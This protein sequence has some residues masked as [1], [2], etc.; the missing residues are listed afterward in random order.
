MFGSKMNL[1]QSWALGPPEGSVW[2]RRGIRFEKYWVV[3][4]SWSRPVGVGARRG[5]GDSERLGFSE[6]RKRRDRSREG[7]S[8]PN[9]PRRDQV[10]CART[11][12]GNR[13]KNGEFSRGVEIIPGW[14]RD[15]FYSGERTVG[16]SARERCTVAETSCKMDARLV[17]AGL[18][19]TALVR[20]S[21]RSSGLPHP[22]VRFRPLP[23]ARAGAQG[24]AEAQVVVPPDSKPS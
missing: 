18:L 23:A 14:P 5:F 16:R 21:I 1:S 3:T 24:T 15:L 12:S 13:R 11:R 22:G 20:G 8:G 10:D 6:F 4:T 17:S 7:T 2:S 19:S 9:L